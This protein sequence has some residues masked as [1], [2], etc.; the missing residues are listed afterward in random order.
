M[1]KYTTIVPLPF[2]KKHVKERV[3]LSDLPS[4]PHRKIFIYHVPVSYCLL[5]L[6]QPGPHPQTPPCLSAQIHPQTS[7]HLRVWRTPA[8]PQL[9][10]KVL[11]VPLKAGRGATLWSHRS[12]LLCCAEELHFND[13]Q[14]PGSPEAASCLPLGWMPLK[15]GMD[16]APSFLCKCTGLILAILSFASNS[17]HPIASKANGETVKEYNYHTSLNITCEQI[18]G[19][20]SEQMR[21]PGPGNLHVEI[22]LSM[23]LPKGPF[24]CKFERMGLKI[25]I[26]KGIFFSE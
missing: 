7:L 11:P 13:L 18:D 14:S 20:E 5:C 24:T 4:Q 10:P 6:L 9:L 22:T 21:S 17:N 12:K 15:I 25:S 19:K 1:P 26:G 16:H 3:R 2:F 23:L 8:L